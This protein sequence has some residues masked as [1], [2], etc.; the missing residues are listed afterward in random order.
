MGYL[1]VAT[2]VA[3]QHE[4][5]GPLVVAVEAALGTRPDLAVSASE[6]QADDVGIAEVAE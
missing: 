4:G 1:G 6:E 3:E 5:V 2:L